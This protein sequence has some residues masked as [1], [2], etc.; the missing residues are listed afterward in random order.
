MYDEKYFDSFFI[1]VKKDLE[2]KNVCLPSVSSIYLRYKTPFSVLISTIISLRTKDSTT[3]NSSISLLDKASTCKAMLDLDK[4]EIEKL[5]YPC[6]FYKTKAQTILDICTTLKDKF[7]YKVPDNQKDL[8]SLKGVGIKTANLVLNLGFNTNAICVDCH[9][10]QISNRLN[11]I[12][13]K[14]AE[15]SEVELQKIMPEKHWIGLNELLVSFGQTICTSVSPYC[16]ICSE[17]SYCPKT[18]VTTSR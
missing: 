16:S 12:S 2:N 18:N 13:I 9:V 14:T 8:L 17:N 11:W 5:I 6:C 7:N 10:H 4:K 15:E 1:R 3:L